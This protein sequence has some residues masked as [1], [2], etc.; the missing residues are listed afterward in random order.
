MGE[1]VNRSSRLWDTGEINL[2]DGGIEGGVSVHTS[3]SMGRFKTT[4]LQ[5]RR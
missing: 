3:L 4:I 1:V 2:L 5:R